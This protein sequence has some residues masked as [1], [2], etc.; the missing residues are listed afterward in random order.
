MTP[1]YS[2]RGLA[3]MT[4]KL[5]IP[6]S[7]TDREEQRKLNRHRADAERW[8]SKLQR[9]YPKL[10]EIK[11]AYPLK[12]LR[13]YPD[14]NI[15]TQPNFVRPRIEESVRV[16]RL[17]K[18]FPLIN[19][20]HAG[21]TGDEERSPSLTSPIDQ[22][23]PLSTRKE[24]FKEARSAHVGLRANEHITGS[25]EAQRLAWQSFSVPE[26]GRIDR[27]RE[28]MMLS[29]LVADDLKLE[30]D[31]ERNRLPEWRK[32]HTGR[33]AEEHKINAAG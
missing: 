15:L 28:A 33:F 26:K 4:L 32:S 20:R 11:T 5:I 2:V 21:K 9:P 7:S 27:G 1:P 25:E 3:T 16:S 22:A 31:G 19:T 13:H 8:K 30:A 23:I 24:T 29:G 10:S 17:L 14:A 6:Q 18:Q 12:L